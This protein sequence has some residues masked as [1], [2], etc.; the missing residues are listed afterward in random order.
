MKFCKCLSAEAIPEWRD[1]YINYKALKKLVKARMFESLCRTDDILA[2]SS[3]CTDEKVCQADVDL[4]VQGLQPEVLKVHE[5][6]SSQVSIEMT[7]MSD[8]EAAVSALKLQQVAK[9]E[10]QLA[11]AEC[12]IQQHLR[13]GNKLLGRL[14]YL[15]KYAAANE[16][17]VRKIVKKFNKNIGTQLLHDNFSRDFS[18]HH[19]A[20]GA[21]LVRMKTGTNIIHETLSKF[22]LGAQLLLPK[23]MSVELLRD[24]WHLTA[25]APA[26][27]ST[28]D[29]QTLQQHFH[30]PLKDVSKHFGVCVTVFKRICRSLGIKRW[31]ARKVKMVQAKRAKLCK[32]IGLLDDVIAT[33]Q[34]SVGDDPTGEAMLKQ[35]QRAVLDRVPPG[36]RRVKIWDHKNKR[37]L[38]GMAAPLE[39]N[40][41]NYL[42]THPDRE[43][44]NGQDLPAGAAKPEQQ[45]TDAVTEQMAVSIPVTSS[46]VQ[47]VKCEAAETVFHADLM[48]REPPC[49]SSS[50]HTNSDLIDVSADTPWTEMDI[51]FDMEGLLDDERI[52]SSDFRD[53]VFASGLPC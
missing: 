6:F 42:I 15:E 25:V 37:K 30:R 49:S 46:V 28:L 52:M 1:H 3:C 40:I 36:K 21:L 2:S 38:T 43:R 26:D 18:F 11:N 32:R 53:S 47:L 23:T 29:L 41:E 20:R 50:S 13:T 44:Y 9:P 16:E 34:P 8:L 35:L 27:P 12:Q 39:V 45:T 48:I 14:G 19:K 51:E 7:N 22:L 33:M 10:A 24:Q 5:F 4:F 17:G 31:P